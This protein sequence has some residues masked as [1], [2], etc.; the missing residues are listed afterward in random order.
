MV[1]AAQTH[2]ILHMLPN[3]NILMDHMLAILMFGVTPPYHLYPFL[4]SYM[5]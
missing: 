2:Q 3:Y 5:T 4:V 1:L